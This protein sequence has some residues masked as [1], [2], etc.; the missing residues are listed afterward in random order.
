M[1]PRLK[2]RGNCSGDSTVATGDRSRGCE[3]WR[4]SLGPRTARGGAVVKEAV[5][6]GEAR[7]ERSPGFP[8]HSTA[9]RPADGLLSPLAHV[10]ISV[11][12]PSVRADGRRAG[13]RGR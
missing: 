1:G 2:G 3:R 7:C 12:R 6:T 8:H 11:R 5:L 10:R 9:R 4:E 13:G